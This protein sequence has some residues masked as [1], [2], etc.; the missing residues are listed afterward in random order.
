M[1]DRGFRLAL[2]PDLSK[3]GMSFSKIEKHNIFESKN[4]KLKMLPVSPKTFLMGSKSLLTSPKAIP[5]SVGEG[6]IL[7]SLNGTV[8][9]TDFSGNPI[10][11]IC[12]LNS[13]ITSISEF[14]KGELIIAGCE[15]GNLFVIDKRKSKVEKVPFEHKFPVT[16]IDI[17]R[18]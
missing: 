16:C 3:K 5:N 1:G 4:F 13:S 14:I 15:N 12:E 10:H 9:I 6:L 11:K 18:R 17:S 7:G 8:G 2:A